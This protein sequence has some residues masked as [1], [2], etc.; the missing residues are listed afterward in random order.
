MSD[1]MSNNLNCESSKHLA[2]AHAAA[3]FGGIYFIIVSIP[4]GANPMVVVVSF[5]AAS[6]GHSDLRIS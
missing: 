5:S 1:F 3:I 4:I 2:L 6:C